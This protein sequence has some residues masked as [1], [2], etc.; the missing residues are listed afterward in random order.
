MAA[1]ALILSAIPPAA[2]P[3]SYSGFEGTTAVD[4]TFDWNGFAPADVAGNGPD[5]NLR[6]H[7]LPAR[8][9]FGWRPTGGTAT[10]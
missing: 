6:K 8:R 2:T 7:P 3:S 4:S 1:L 5:P 9:S 10:P